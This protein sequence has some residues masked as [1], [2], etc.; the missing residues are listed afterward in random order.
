MTTRVLFM[1]SPEF[2][3]PSLQALAAASHQYQIV[4]V[5]T[6]PD[7]PA[8]RG[9]Q[10]TANAVKTAALALNLPVFDLQKIKTPETSELLKSLEPDI[11]V[12][13]AYGR[14]LPPHLLALPRLGC[15]NVHAS[16]LPKWRGASPIAHAILKGDKHAGVAIMQMEAGLDTGAVFGM[17]SLE[18]AAQDTCGSLS[19]RLSH[20]GAQLLMRL[21]PQIMEKSLVAVA[22]DHL[23][24]TYAPLLKKNDGW[25]DWQKSA[26]ELEQQIRAFD[27]W[28]GT[29]TSLAGQ[30]VQVLSATLGHTPTIAPSG[31]LISVSQ[32]G[33]VVAAGQ[34]SALCLTQL[35]PAGKN[36]MPAAAWVAGRSVDLGTRFDTSLPET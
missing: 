9:R 18:I 32:E 25:L 4:G 29:F 28:P 10:L 14:I 5:V 16:L 6:Q 33:L 24:A 35:K 15:V 31:T 11:A 26:R 36:A 21:L 20:L 23:Q 19:E 27:P 12:V 1:G 34:H 17:E 8:G 30:R 2:A 7:K 3:V 22:Q 13:A